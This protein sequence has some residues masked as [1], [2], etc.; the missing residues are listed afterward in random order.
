MNG[1]EFTFEAAGLSSPIKQQTFSQ[2][3]QLTS[4]RTEMTQPRVLNPSPTGLR[5]SPSSPSLATS[6]KLIE[7]L[8][9]Q[10]DQ[11]TNTN[12]QLTL[13]SQNLLSKLESYQQK[14][15]KLAESQSLLIHEQDN[16][17]SM[18]NRKDRRIND[19]QTEF[20]GLQAKYEM[21]KME[22]DSNETKAESFDQLKKSKTEEMEK[23]RLQYDTMLESQL[24]Y[25]D[26]YVAELA[27]LSQEIEEFQKS[28]G[29]TLKDALSKESKN[30]ERLRILME[31][32]ESN[33]KTDKNEAEA[34]YKEAIDNLKLPSWLSL[35]YQS[36]NTLLAFAGNNNLEI[37][38]SSDDLINDKTVTELENRLKEEHEKL[39]KLK[40]S[41]SRLR[42]PSPNLAQNIKRRSFYGAGTA[43]STNVLLPGTRSTSSTHTSPNPNSYSESRRILRNSS[44]VKS[45]I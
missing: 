23:L 24:H 28:R 1:H 4:G 15:I 38:K 17:V 42:K 35:F 21:I 2:E 12:I 16:L 20:Q 37:S 27:S 41:N 30:I 8:H 33:D 26:H 22:N 44:T 31:K 18:I 3:P 40:V 13:Q 29:K 45:S 25:R 10:I 6:T 36:R 43:S 9:Q 39:G 19:V 5:Q 32:I 11:L 34:K 7:N 14:E